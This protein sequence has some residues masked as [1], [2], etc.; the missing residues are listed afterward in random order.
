VRTR[1]LRFSPGN[2][3]RLFPLRRRGQIAATRRSDTRE[4]LGYYF[5]NVGILTEATMKIAF[6]CHAYSPRVRSLPTISDSYFIW[7]NDPA[8]RLARETV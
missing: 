4:Q 8:D 6:D 5:G 1:H 3:P 2:L 7:R